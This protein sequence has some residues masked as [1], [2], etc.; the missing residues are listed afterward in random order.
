MTSPD[1][2]FFSKLLDSIF[3]TLLTRLPIRSGLMSPS[4]DE[5]VTKTTMT[6]E[7]VIVTGL[8]IGEETKGNT[9][10]WLTWFL[11]AHTI[12]R[13]GGCQAGHHVMTKDGQTQVF[14]HFGAGTFE[15]AKTH[16][17]HMVIN[18]VDLFSEAI[19]LEEKGVENPFDLITIDEDCLSITP[20]HGAMSRFRE[21]M[22]GNDHKKGTVGMG[23]GEA[24]KDAQRS[25]ELA[26]RARD[27]H[28]REA[29][30][31]KIETIRQY[32]QKQAM[33][34]IASMDH[35]DIPPEA[36]RELELLED[37]ELAS[38]TVNSMVYLADLVHIVGTNYLDELLQKPGTIVNEASHGALLHP[39]YG[40]VPHVTQV[41]PTSRDVLANLKDHDYQ[42]KIVR[43]GV[44]RCYMTRHGAGPLVSYS[45][46]MT[47]GITETHNDVANDWLGPFRNGQYDIVALRYAIEISGGKKSFDGLMISYLDVLSEHDEWKVCTAYAYEGDADDLAQYF[48]M[49]DGNIVGIKV[50]PDTRDNDHYAH[51]LRLTQLLKQCRPVLETLIAQNGKTLEE[52]FLQY[53]E[54]HLGIPVVATAHGPKKQDRQMR[55]G[56]EHLFTGVALN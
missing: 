37:T 6:K 19:E 8:G 41:D 21:I 13:S 56:W 27:F 53:V 26:I 16:L 29:L 33:E 7:M 51:Q 25:E 45:E 47:S 11:W 39:W 35:R 49:E 52:V 20:F 18:P 2:S 10:E 9:V 54:A 14:S 32:K 43:L 46:E 12:L 38:Q 28:S 40:F 3:A 48:D 44:S 17:V 36:L 55:S 1:V 50:H 30:V 24:I 42:G 15:G 5:T 22:R 4:K 34:I 23:V 31:Q